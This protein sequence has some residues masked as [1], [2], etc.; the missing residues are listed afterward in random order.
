[1][2]QIARVLDGQQVLHFTSSHITH[3]VVTALEAPMMQR[4]LAIDD[5]PAVTSLLKR[6]LSYEGFVVQAAS[7][8]EEGLVIARDRPPDLVILDIMMPDLDGLVVL[9]RLRAVDA[10]LPVL[11]LTAKDAPADQVEGLGL[12]ADDYV[13]KPFTFEVLVARVRALL[14]RQQVEQPAIL[15]FTDLSLDPASRSVRR[16]ARE[17]S[18]TS[19]EFKLLEEFMKHPR[20]VLA[21]EVMQRIRLSFHQFFEQLREHTCPVHTHGN[22]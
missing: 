10:R 3:V 6:G 7:S 21:K 13:V 16:G 4:I 12:G 1:M 17:I 14:R 9:Q 18:L 2:H 8:G 19:V 11:M 5:D 22:F 15:R 20:H